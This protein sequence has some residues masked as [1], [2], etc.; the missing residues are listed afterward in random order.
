MHTVLSLEMGGLEKVVADIV[1]GFDKAK[2]NVE[3][4]CFDTRGHFAATLADLGIT[5]NLVPRNQNRY[6]A[7]FPFRLRKLL[8]DR[9]TDI[10]HMHSGTFFLGTQ[11]ALLAGIPGMVYTDHGRHL[12]DPKLLLVLDR[13]C[14]FFVKKIIAVSSE[15]EKYLVEVVRLPAAKTTTII[16]G[17]NTDL[18][19]PGPKS[20]ALL[21]EL[22]IPHTH[23]VIGTVGR[24]VEVKDQVSMIRAFAKACEKQTDITLLFIGDGP[25]RPLLQQTAHD[26][27]IS[28]RVVFAGTR[29]DIARVMNLIDIF[30]L[31]SLSEGTSI[32]LL[33][34]MASGATPIVTAVGGNPSLVRHEVNGILVPPGDIAAMATAINVLL[35]NDAVRARYSSNAVATVRSNYSLTGMIDKYS[36]IYNKLCMI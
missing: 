4:C 26:Y 15:L 30:M 28:E 1:S 9:K 18:F 31:T 12:V 16:N 19:T 2:Y 33:E 3:V 8:Q 34:A 25:L 32:S 21:D 13:F 17:I 11:A 24:L 22:K 10:I 5:V 23:R 14:G 20:P 35:G 36:D 6:D 29:N 7:I 27:N